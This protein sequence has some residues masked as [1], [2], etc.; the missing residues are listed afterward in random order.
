MCSVDSTLTFEPCLHSLL[1][2]VH[3]TS[4]VRCVHTTQFDA[5]FQKTREMGT[6]P[7]AKR[8]VLPDVLLTLKPLNLIGVVNHRRSDD[9][10]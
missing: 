1:N 10:Q 5:L 2:D 6:Q 8:D 4:V 9:V 3:M 7:V